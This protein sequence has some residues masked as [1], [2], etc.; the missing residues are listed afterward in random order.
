[1]FITNKEI[2]VLNSKIII[3]KNITE[4]EFEKIKSYYINPIE[5]RE[6]PI[7]SFTYEKE[8]DMAKDVEIIDGFIEFD[9][10]EM[11]NFKSKYGIGMDMEDLM[12]CQGYYKEEKRNPSITEIKLINTYWSDHC[13]HTTFMNEITDIKF[14]DGKYKEIFEMALKKYL[15][16]RDFV[17]ENKER[18]ISLMDLATI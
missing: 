6:V 2:D 3:L 13:R 12:F 7:H 17:Y 18:A 4:K 11:E 8:L 15:A 5:M 16:S 14:H 1:D 9:F 10:D